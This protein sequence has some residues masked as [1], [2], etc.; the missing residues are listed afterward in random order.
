MQKARPC[1]GRIW[2]ARTWQSTSFKSRASMS[3][4]PCTP[5]SQTMRVNV[6]GSMLLLPL[7]KSQSKRRPTVATT[8]LRPVRHQAYVPRGQSYGDPRPLH[9]RIVENAMKH[10]SWGRRAAVGGFGKQSI[11]VRRIRCSLLASRSYGRGCWRYRANFP[12]ARAR[13]TVPG[14]NERENGSLAN[15]MFEVRQ[16]L[17]NDEAWASAD[18][19]YNIADFEPSL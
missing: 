4:S 3:W 6:S 18:Q 1:H 14:G 8:A 7:L 11:A 5:K 17:T 9:S 16:Y 15:G 10:F 19:A 12:N 2:S 13:A